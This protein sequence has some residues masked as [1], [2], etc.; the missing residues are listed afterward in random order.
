MAR[1]KKESLGKDVVTFSLRLKNGTY[2]VLRE[3]SNKSGLSMHSLVVM[4]INEGI[5]RDRERFKVPPKKG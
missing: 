1:P 4:Y 5:Y 3:I 2:S